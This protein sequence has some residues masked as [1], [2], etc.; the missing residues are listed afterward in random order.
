MPKL[1]YKSIEFSERKRV[2]IDS[3]NVIIADYHR[4]GFDLTLRQLY[5]QFVSRNLIP[6]TE[7]SYKSLGDLI[8]DARLAGLIDWN[9]I[10]DRTRNVR[11]NQHW[12]KPSEVIESAANS[13]ALDKWTD[14]RHYVE[15]WVEKDA[16]RGIVAQ[17]CSRLD[18]R[19]FSCRGYTSLSEMWVA[20][21]RLR[22]RIK[23]GKKAIILHLG[24]H[25]P[26]GLDMTRDIKDRL[27]L[28]KCPATIERIALNINQVRQYGFPPNPAKVT[29]SRYAAYQEQ[30]GE[31]S[32]ELDA[33]DPQV[34]VT[35]IEAGIRRYLQQDL[36]DAA[37]ARENV[38]KKG[39][40]A[41]AANY[42]KVLHGIR[43]DKI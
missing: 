26:S 13:F 23:A 29:D 10:V 17:V 27:D 35:I 4:R 19:Y 24:D 30:Y 6:N 25:D 18:V 40:R 14:Q 33:V 39:L 3:A 37:V 42:V 32:W 41:I 7:A 2:L 43:D 11:G 31:S 12:E 15:V 9:A 16:L 20:A 28:F 34:L 21:Q 38:A 22:E 8:G 5:Y 36:F 1:C